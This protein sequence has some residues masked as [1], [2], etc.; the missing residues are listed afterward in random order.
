MEGSAR[1]IRKAA[2]HA[3]GSRESIPATRATPRGR[4]PR[5]VK[6]LSFADR[7][8]ENAGLGSG[9]RAALRIVAGLPVRE[10][11]IGDVQ[12]AELSGAS[13]SCQQVERRWPDG[14][15][16]LPLGAIG[17]GKSRCRLSAGHGFVSK[18]QILAEL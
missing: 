15:R 9:C 13:L 14:G 8:P 12:C 3:Q 2:H 16:E 18:Q 6:R 17:A 1:G 11:R 10:K 7:F 5:S 4:M